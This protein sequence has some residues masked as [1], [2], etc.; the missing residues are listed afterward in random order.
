MVAVA[1]NI[2][3]CREEELGEDLA[4]DI[5]REVGI[6]RKIFRKIKERHDK[7]DAKV[8]REYF[9]RQKLA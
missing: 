4:Q 8:V 5:E 3:A 9:W 7:N 2:W 1:N 6:W